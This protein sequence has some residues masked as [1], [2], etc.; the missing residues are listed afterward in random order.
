M[1]DPNGVVQ[2]KEADLGPAHSHLHAVLQRGRFAVTAEL[3]PP[4]GA[5]IAPIRRKAKLLRDWQAPPTPE[6]A[7]VTATH[8]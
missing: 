8:P 2:L 1:P 6:E 4:R 7:R 3:G 5:T